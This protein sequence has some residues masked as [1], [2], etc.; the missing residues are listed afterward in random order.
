[1]EAEEKQ[2][3]DERVRQRDEDKNGLH[4]EREKGT[5]VGR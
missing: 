5:Y 2:N 1:M 4:F 3:S